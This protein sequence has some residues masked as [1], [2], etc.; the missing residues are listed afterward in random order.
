MRGSESPDVELCAYS[1]PL[2]YPLLNYLRE[3]SSIMVS[4]HH[5]ILSFFSQLCSV[6]DEYVFEIYDAVKDMLKQ[7]I[8]EIKEGTGCKP[9]G[10]AI[11]SWFKLIRSFSSRRS[12]IPQISPLFDESMAWCLT[13]PFKIRENSNQPQIVGQ[14]SFG[15]GKK[16]DFREDACLNN[17]YYGT[18]LMCTIEFTIKLCKD[19]KGIKS[20]NFDA[21][22]NR[23]LTFQ[24]IRDLRKKKM[25]LRD[26][27]DQEPERFPGIFDQMVQCMGTYC[28]SVDPSDNSSTQSSHVIS[29]SSL[30]QYTPPQHLLVKMGFDEERSLR[31]SAY[32]LIER[33]GGGVEALFDAK[34]YSFEG[35]DR[36]RWEREMEMER[37]SGEEEENEINLC[38]IIKF[39][40]CWLE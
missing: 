34:T 27:E 19:G 38:R 15:I 7:W 9:Q 30:I 1:W 29:H 35:F 24:P 2:F 10:W 40:N 4:S 3:S 14:N 26:G 21:I 32:D 11:E 8:L 39:E 18:N 28:E 20:I 16:E 12:L 22:S 25:E 36:D 23:E 5:S 33:T 31:Q 13:K 6:S 17:Y 37:V